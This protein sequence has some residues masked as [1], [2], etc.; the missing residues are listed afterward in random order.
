MNTRK[1]D[2]IQL[3][4]TQIHLNTHQCRKESQDG[5]VQTMPILLLCLFVR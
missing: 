2:F 4:T 5:N 1:Q 3:I